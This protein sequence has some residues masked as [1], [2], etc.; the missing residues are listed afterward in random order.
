MRRFAETRPLHGECG[1][2]MVLGEALEDADGI[3]HPMLGLLPVTTSFAKRKLNLGYRVA[4]L[5]NKSIFGDPQ[6]KLVGHEFHYASLISAPPTQ[7]V[8]FAKCSDA[9]GNDLSFAGHRLGH[10]SGTF[11]HIIARDYAI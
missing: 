2:Y 8:A 4:H 9:E 10:V 1:G 7:D 11:F 3:S 5:V 6:T